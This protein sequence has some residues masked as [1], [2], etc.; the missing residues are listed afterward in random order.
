MQRICAAL[1]ALAAATVSAQPYPNRAIRIVVPYPPGG[2]ADIT[3]RPIA[4]MLSERW[5]QPVVIENHGGASGMIGAD[6]VAK[7]P[8]D[9]YTLMVSASSEVALNVAVFPKM[10]YDPVR[11]FAPITLA[12]V[13]PMALVV[14]SSVPVTSLKEYIGLAKAKPGSMTFGSTGSG[15]PHHF[16][17]EWLKMLAQ[18]DIVHVPYKGSGPLINDLLGGHSPS[19]FAT[20]LPAMQH[21][22]SGKLRAL[23]VTT[24]KRVPL[25]PDVPA[26]AETLPGFDISQWN[27]VWAPAGTPKDVLDKLSTEITRIV[28]S[29]DYKARMSEQ[30]SEAIG[31]SPSELAAFQKAEID[32]YRKIAQ[33]A[34]IKVD[35]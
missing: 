31:N 30:G 17:G 23:A 21:V 25:L 34:N 32:K 26:L 9:G 14:H 15:S 7:A 28:Q 4:Q 27:A 19:G 8:P 10:P 33:Q 1:L 13:T 5:G 2:G 22:K 12:T 24:Q 16:A 35:Q 3:A 11:D 20:L 18:I 29:A 6:I